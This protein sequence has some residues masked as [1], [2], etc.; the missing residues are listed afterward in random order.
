MR[1]QDFEASAEAY[2]ELQRAYGKRSGN[3][4]L[5]G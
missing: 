4:L 1:D 2:G 3:P 5:A